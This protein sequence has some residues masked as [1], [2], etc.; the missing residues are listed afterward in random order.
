MNSNF[1]FYLFI[2]M[3]VPL[4]SECSAMF[5]SLIPNFDS[6]SLTLCPVVTNHRKE[7]NRLPLLY[8]EAIVS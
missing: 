3:F 1:V 2:C 4:W 8:L 7:L 5:A 6:H